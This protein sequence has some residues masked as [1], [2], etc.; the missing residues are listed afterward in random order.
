MCTRL[1]R[2]GAPRLIV[3]NFSHNKNDSDPL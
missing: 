1:R 3:A 2:T